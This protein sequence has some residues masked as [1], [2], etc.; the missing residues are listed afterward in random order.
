MVNLLYSNPLPTPQFASLSILLQLDIP[1]QHSNHNDHNNNESTD[2]KIIRN[3]SSDE[4]IALANDNDNL[5]VSMTSVTLANNEVK[6]V[7]LYPK[8]M[9]VN[10]L[11]QSPAADSPTIDSDDDSNSEESPPPVTTTVA[12]TATILDV[13]YDDNLEPYYTIKIHGSGVE[14]QTDNAHIA[15]IDDTATTHQPQQDGLEQKSSLEEANNTPPLRHAVLQ[16]SI[17]VITPQTLLPEK[18]H[19][20]CMEGLHLDL[21]EG[22]GLQDDF[23]GVGTTEDNEENNEE[24]LSDIVDLSD[25]DS[26][27]TPMMMRNNSK[28]RFG[29]GTKE[30]SATVAG[31]GGGDEKKKGRNGYFG[32]LPVRIYKPHHCLL[33]MTCYYLAVYTEDI[34]KL[35]K[36]DDDNSD[37]PVKTL[38]QHCASVLVPGISLTSNEQRGGVIVLTVGST[39]PAYDLYGASTVI[40]TLPQRLREGMTQLSCVDTSPKKE[41]LLTNDEV[42]Q[43]QQQQLPEKDGSRRF[44]FLGKSTTNRSSQQQ[45]QKLLQQLSSQSAT[46]TTTYDSAYFHRLYMALLATIL[47][48][49]DGYMREHDDVVIKSFPFSPVSPVVGTPKSS[50]VS[51][52]LKKNRFTFSRRKVNND[53]EYTFGNDDGGGDEERPDFKDEEGG[54]KSNNTADMIRREAQKL[55]VL[56]I[57]EEDMPI[58]RYSHLIGEHTTK[59]SSSPRARKS[60]RK[61]GAAASSGRF[62]R[63]AVPSD[64]S[65]FEYRPSMQQRMVGGGGMSVSGF[66]TSTSEISE[67]ASIMTGD[68]TAYTTSSQSSVPTL[69][70]SKRDDSSTSSSSSSRSR[71]FMFMKK[72]KEKSPKRKKGKPLSAIPQDQELQLQQ[73]VYDPFGNDD[74]EGNA[75]DSIAEN[76]VFQ[77]LNT[78]NISVPVDLDDTPPESPQKAIVND[79]NKSYSYE[80]E[81]KDSEAS[82]PESNASTAPESIA[83]PEELEPEPVPEPEPEPEPEPTRHLDVSLALNED[84]TCEYKQ[85]KLSTLTVEGTIQ[86]RMSSSYEGEP[87]LEAP[88]SIPFNLLFKDHSGH[89]RTLQENKKFVENVSNESETANREFTYTV[90][91]PREEEYFPVVRYKCDSSL[92]PVPIR[93]QSRVRTQGK[94]CRIA[95]QISSN[96]QNPS[97][98]VHLTVIMGVPPGLNGESLKCN[99]PGGVWNE[100][101]RVVLW[102][103]S[104]LGGGEKFQL[105]AILEMS[106]DLLQS[107]VDPADRLEFPVM[108]RCQCVGGQLSDVAL[109]VSDVDMFPAA[110]SKNVMQRF[111]VS[112]KEKK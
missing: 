18:S 79:L 36:G 59:K 91:I 16:E 3:I 63:P 57:A 78:S 73:P 77:S 42:L 74:D 80:S 68:H 86:V 30:G 34:P 102:C 81:G 23:L 12:M 72:K 19:L 35:I 46:T 85:S 103:V 98:L 41:I 10:Y 14:K 52:G 2:G 31:G 1:S 4:I 11:K 107:G 38:F 105:Q 96:P 99:P 110:I 69:S 83:E 58:P 111:R 71:R 26:T 66:T 60:P 104:E 95:L 40:A 54:A 62:G 64:L 108:A 39:G 82:A 8:G 25:V 50:S 9:L 29:D 21:M 56:S 37:D 55:E 94:L 87:P 67:D 28:V 75:N 90:T 15:L 17:T 65:G 70:R 43:R 27:T 89:V 109:D 45:Q 97:D 20:E 13:H 5:K 92:R 32:N 47:D 106:D 51:G 112:H 22:Y 49:D 44:P 101:K 61:G 93:V 100:S 33:G 84:L 53:Q 76:G 24:E 6:E 48:D 7:P 88:A